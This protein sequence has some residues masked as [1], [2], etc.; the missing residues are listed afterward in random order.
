MQVGEAGKDKQ[1][2]QH[3]L[4]LANAGTPQKRVE[5]QACRCGGGENHVTLP[6]IPG[7]RQQPRL[8]GEAER[9]ECHSA[10][11][12]G[13][14]AQ[15]GDIRDR[16]GRGV[17]R[18]QQ[19]QG[20]QRRGPGLEL[21]LLAENDFRINVASPVHVEPMRSCQHRPPGISPQQGPSRVNDR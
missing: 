8:G 20:Q 17:V 3:D 13:Q 11:R 19:D 6:N 9:K 7:R 10:D 4:D 2:I 5:A 21:D 12:R 15:V 18:P 1:R 14:E 16:D